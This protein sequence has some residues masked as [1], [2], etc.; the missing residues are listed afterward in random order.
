KPGSDF[1]AI[2]KRETDEAAGKSS[3]GDLGWFARDAM[4][5]EFADAAFALA[6]GQISGVVESPFGFHIIKVEEKK[7]AQKTE[8]AD[9]ER[10]IAKKILERE[11]RPEV[12]SA[13]AKR[14]LEALKAG[15]DVTPILGELGLKWE[16][17]GDQS[18]NARFL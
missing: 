11:K 16:E 9:A 5:K 4:V 14:V 13:N 10:D 2:A 18:A 3:G 8:L 7:A 1:A 15:Q 6:A 12:A 17:T